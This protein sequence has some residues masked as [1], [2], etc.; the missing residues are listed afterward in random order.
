MDSGMLC[1]VWSPRS[2]NASRDRT[3]GR[4]TADAFEVNDPVRS[5]MKKNFLLT[6]KVFEVV[7]NATHPCLSHMCIRPW[8]PAWTS[9]L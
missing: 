2:R 7:M 8:I 6:V 1:P 9:L 4:G 5:A 3:R